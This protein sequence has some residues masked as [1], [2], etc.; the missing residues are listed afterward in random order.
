MWH[1]EYRLYLYPTD[2]TLNISY[3]KLESALRKI[4]F[5]DTALK[6]DK[7]YRYQAGKGFLSLI[8][9]MGCSPNIEIKPQ[10]DRP[11]CYVEI[12]KSTHKPHFIV[13][14]NV[15][16]VNCPHCKKPLSHFVDEVLSNPTRLFQ[17]RCSLCKTV[18]N[19]EKINWRKSAFI[20]Q[21]WLLVGN[22][23]EAEAVPDEKLLATLQ[24][25]SGCQ[26]QYAYIR[27]N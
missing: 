26:W 19:P 15:K 7:N 24:Q 5:I 21:T 16:K 10:Q 12:T 6:S 17:Q 23:Y 13:G 8:C 9:F 22:I 20:A 27:T 11:F 2:A 4:A 18:I 1:A 25:V 3:K 14:R